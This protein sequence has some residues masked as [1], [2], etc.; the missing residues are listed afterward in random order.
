MKANLSKE[1]A[2]A[3]NEFCRIV[4][5]VINAFNTSPTKDALET[6]LFVLNPYRQS[7][8]KKVA[9]IAEKT[10]LQFYKLKMMRDAVMVNA[11]AGGQPG[12]PG[13]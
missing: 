12:Q 5:P 9:R 2:D 3:W 11:L 1:E 10:F 8:Y 13:R 7:K 4:N 6:V